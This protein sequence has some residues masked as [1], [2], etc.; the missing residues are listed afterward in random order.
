MARRPFHKPD[1]QGK[2]DGLCGIYSV[3]NS[4][5]WLY[6]LREQ[7]LDRLFH[8]LC[9]SIADKFPEAL[10]EGLGVPEMQRLLRFAQTHLVEKHGTSDL[11]WHM[12]LMRA[13]FD[14]VETFWSSVRDQI[15]MGKGSVVIVGLNKPWDHWTVAREVTRESV[16][17]FDSYDMR[18]YKFSSFTL[19]QAEAGHLAGQK[20]LIDTH[21]SFRLTRGNGVAA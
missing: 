16:A 12:P 1:Q 13:Q 4:V 9:E 7:Q 2:F 6:R 18:R 3:L 11:T 15:A 19:D 14:S 5:K 17:F 21:Q 10:W 8:A 20:I